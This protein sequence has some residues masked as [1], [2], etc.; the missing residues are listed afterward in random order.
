MAARCLLCCIAVTADAAVLSYA[1]F[2]GA[3]L[4]SVQCASAAL[5]ME[6]CG[7]VPHLENVMSARCF[8]RM[9]AA[10]VVQVG[11][12]PGPVAHLLLA[13]HFPSR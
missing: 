9:H 6:A 3:P 13:M 12:V 8:Q 7:P 10:G 5:A 4:C 11:V 2:P 1:T